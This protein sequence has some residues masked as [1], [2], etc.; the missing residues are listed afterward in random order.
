MLFITRFFVKLSVKRVSLRR[1]QKGSDP[2]DQSESLTP[3]SDDP[4]LRKLLVEGILSPGLRAG[5]VSG[6]RFL[7]TARGVLWC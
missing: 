6:Q 7:G 1:N 3:I 4:C 5:G 2:R